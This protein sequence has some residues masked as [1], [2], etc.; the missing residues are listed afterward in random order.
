VSAAP[1]KG[2]AVEEIIV[3]G[4]H[5]RRSNFD[6]ASPLDVIDEVDL[7]LSATPDIGD[8]I[9]DQTFQIGVNANSAPFEAGSVDNQ[10]WQQGA[11]VFANIRGLGTRATMTLMDGHRVPTIVNGWGSDTRRGGADVTNMYPRIAIRSVETIL[12]GASAL[13]GAEAVAGVIN[14]KPRKN[15]D[16]IELNYEQQQALDNG[17]PVRQFGLLMGSQGEQTS[18]IFALEIRDQARMKMTDRPEYIVSSA[19]WTGQLNPT[20]NEFQRGVPGDYTVPYRNSQG[21]FVA[22]QGSWYRANSRWNLNDTS[23][24]GARGDALNRAG[25][26]PASDASGTGRYYGVRTVDPGCGHPFGAGPNNMWYGVNSRPPIDPANATKAHWTVS[27]TD[28]RSGDLTPAQR[29]EIWGSAMGYNDVQKVGSFLNGFIVA[30]MNGL[31][32]WHGTENDFD[33][34]QSAAGDCREVIA[35]FQDMQEERYQNTAYGYVEHEFSE[36][37]SVRAE[38]VGS[39]LDYNTRDMPLPVDEWDFLSMYGPNV[40]IVPG[41]NP[42][43]P[44]RAHADRSNVCS[45]LDPAVYTFCQGR[46]GPTDLWDDDPLS[47]L[48][49]TRIDYDDLNGNGRYDYLKEPGEWLIFGQDTNGD[50]L[51]DRDID[52]DGVWDPLF[53]R[54]PEARPIVLGLGDANGNGIPDRFDPFTIGDP[55]LHGIRLFEDVR[56]AKSGDDYSA[57]PKT[58]VNNN[59]DIMYEDPAGFLYS[60]ARTRA[61]NLRIR[62]GATVSF[63][64]SGW[65]VD[66]DGIFQNQR[67]LERE[68]V[69]STWPMAVDAARCQGG[70]RADVCWNPFSTAWLMTDADG[71][72][73]SGKMRSELTADDIAYLESINQMSAFG[74]YDPRIQPNGIPADMVGFRPAD[75]P[76]VNTKREVDAAGITLRTRSRDLSFKLVDL[77]ASNADLFELPW[78]NASLGIAGGLHWREE[79]ERFVP[80]DLAQTTLGG[81]NI[82]TQRTTETT[83]AAFVE[84]AIPLLRDSK[85]GSLEVQAAGRYTVVTTKNLEGPF[86]QSEFDAWI[87]K[88]AARYQPPIENISIRGSITRGFVVPAMFTLFGTQPGT[89]S[90]TV[91]DYLCDAVPEAGACITAAGGAQTGVLT[92]PA[93]NFALAAETSN[94]W[95]VGTSLRFLDGSLT[96]DVDYTDVKFNG[97]VERI[98]PASNLNNN[99]QGFREFF[100]GYTTGGCNLATGPGS[101]IDYDNQAILAP[102]TALLTAPAYVAALQADTD[103]RT[104]AALA[105]GEGQKILDCRLAAAQAWAMTEKGIGGTVINRDPRTLQLYEVEN[106]WVNQGDAKTRNFI[107]DVS[108]RF[109]GADIPFVG[110]DFGSFEYRF[111]MTQMLEQSL[112]RFSAASGS[113]YAAVAP[114]DGVGNR[115]NT[116]GQT[117]NG[118][119]L[120]QLSEPLPPTPRYRIQSSLR[121]FMGNHTAQLSVRWHSMLTDVEAAFDE[122][123]AAGL[124]TTATFNNIPIADVQEADTCSDQDRDPYC[125]IAAKAYWDVSYTYTAPEVKWLGRVSLNVAMRNIF[126]AKPLPIPSGV[127]HEATIDNIFGRV[128]FLRLTVRP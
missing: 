127:G 2:E 103:P 72:I 37:L 119:D 57:T 70:T 48:G 62:L 91:G 84:L 6:L 1:A 60:K 65:I 122:V 55:N 10:Q 114:I 115:N 74:N 56:Q 26:G 41:D 13:Y 107:Y 53:D 104:G 40:L 19:N 128:A 25:T 121:W 100:T 116:F 108:Y 47:G 17:A 43:N 125:R 50:G 124:L 42:G 118:G 123:K 69:T 4:S 106:P 34:G 113:V 30:P 96:V 51:Y 64:D 20:W 36:R 23:N 59:V 44:F 88:F 16:G 29:Q 58:A 73:I 77:V 5:I 31:T 15:F 86:A 112:K 18:A 28:P 32:P 76:E 101:Y 97:R 82:G 105:A 39:R 49:N 98:G 95:N 120:V 92:G 12:D 24:A 67:R 102:G 79:G 21:N 54:K 11:E 71:Q 85:V 35:D 89:D 117:F 68:Q 8:V 99:Q 75:A 7:E 63:P 111:N 22:P 110:G 45:V 33:S 38:F 87:P 9:F 78:N 27:L 109:D 61:D 81:A 3:T 80:E 93:S 46:G 83:K 126:N 66:A 94:L 52:G 90:S 14:F